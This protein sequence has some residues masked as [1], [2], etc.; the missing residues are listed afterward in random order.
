MTTL[1]HLCPSLPATDDEN[2]NDAA[3]DCAHRAD[4]CRSLD[5]SATHATRLALARWRSGKSATEMQ[6]ATALS[7][8]AQ[9]RWYMHT[10]DQLAAWRANGGF[11]HDATRLA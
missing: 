10:R 8:S 1:T 3:L 4:A 5:Q 2:A 7:M 6:L 9:E 11:E